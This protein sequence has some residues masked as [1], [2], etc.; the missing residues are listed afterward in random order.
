MA[1]LALVLLVDQKPCRPNQGSVQLLDDVLICINNRLICSIFFFSVVVGQSY[2]LYQHHDQNHG[3]GHQPPRNKTLITSMMNGGAA[4]GFLWLTAWLRFCRHGMG[5][6]RFRY[7]PGRWI[8]R[9]VFRHQFL[10]I[11]AMRILRSVYRDLPMAFTVLYTVKLA[12]LQSVK[13]SLPCN[14]KHFCAFA[15]SKIFFLDMIA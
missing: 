3:Y 4:F 15:Q 13:Y 2:D 7:D 12:A 14:S 11:I 1:P 6:R 9:F 8:I 10:R 5:G